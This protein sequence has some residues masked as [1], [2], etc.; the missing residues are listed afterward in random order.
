ME[1]TVSST[2][3][4]YFS[5]WGRLLQLGFTDMQREGSCSG[6]MRESTDF[7]LLLCSWQRTYQTWRPTR[8]VGKELV[9]YPGRPKLRCVAHTS[10]QGWMFTCCWCLGKYHLGWHW[11]ELCVEW[12]LVGLKWTRNLLSFLLQVCPQGSL[13]WHLALSHCS[14]L[15]RTLATQRLCK[16]TRCWDKEWVGICPLTRYSVTKCISF[17][18]TFSTL[19]IEKLGNDDTQILFQKILWTC[20][21]VGSICVA[22]VLLLKGWCLVALVPTQ[23]QGKWMGMQNK[24]A[25]K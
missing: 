24:S 16:E 25:T 13:R 8:C 15:Y 17:I 22:D 11:H 10:S 19:L 1:R 9:S 23:V 21:L 20:W 2:E 3:K 4:L 7:F 14:C 18:T 5:Q 6:S 12:S